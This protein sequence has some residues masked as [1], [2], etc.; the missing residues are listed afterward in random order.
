MRDLM[1]LVKSVGVT[2]HYVER[3]RKVRKLVQEQGRRTA[4][5]L[6]RDRGASQ[7]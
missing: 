4:R 3:R 7:G 1:E 6:I 2:S 5:W